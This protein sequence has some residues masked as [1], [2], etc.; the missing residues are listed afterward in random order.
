MNRR[1]F[2]LI[3]VLVTIAVLGIL[4]MIAVTNFTGT[5][6]N[7]NLEAFAR[8]LAADLQYVQQKNMNG[9]TTY[10]LQFTSTGYSVVVDAVAEKTANIPVS[11]TFDQATSGFTFGA[12]YEPVFQS[13]GSM[14]NSVGTNVLP[15]GSVTT[16]NG[17]EYW[18]CA[19]IQNTNAR[20]SFVRVQTTTGL[21]VI[22]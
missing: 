10:G 13:N 6:R 3:E 21:V 22:Q 5:N 1:G 19:I 4:A 11:V 15:Y 8:Q 20:T 9:V 12:N 14:K 7:K 18:T 17:F 16:V 2:T